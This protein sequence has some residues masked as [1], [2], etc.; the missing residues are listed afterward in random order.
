MLVSYT[1]GGPAIPGCTPCNW[2]ALSGSIVSGAWSGTIAGI[3]AGGPYFV[4]VRA[5]NGTAYATLPSGVKVGLVFDLWGEGQASAIIAGTNGG[6]ANSTYTGLWGVNSPSTGNFYSYDTGPA[7]AT[8]LYPSWTQMV[9][10]DRFSVTGGGGETLPE[11]ASSL[12]QN[13]QNSMGYPATLSEWVRDGAGL[14]VFVW[15]NQVQSQS[16]GIGNGSTTTWC[17]ASNFC[18]NVGEGGTLDFNLAS[19]TGSAF[20]GSISGTTLTVS[21]ITS[22]AL[23][24]GAALSGAG[25]TGSPTLVA[26]TANCS[27]ANLYSGGTGSQWTISASEGTIGSEA[28]RADPSGEPQR[29]ITI[30]PLIR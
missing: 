5:A 6:W 4:S 17:S 29:L 9:A 15:G 26:C 19:L 23:Q 24:P 11:G 27:A 22:G 21:T 3:P 14:N 2:G 20:T 7:L 28:M 10:G 13:L 18:S 25:L 16:V 12:L 8:N 30:P 1:A